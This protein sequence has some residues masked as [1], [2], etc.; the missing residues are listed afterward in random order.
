M[1]KQFFFLL[2]TISLSATANNKK[3]RQDIESIKSMCGCM[4]ISFEFAETIS[5]NKDYKFFD[6]Y[7]S[8]GL[9]LAFV[10]EESTNKIVIQ[11]LL[12]AG[13]D[14]IIKHWR[15]DWIYENTEFFNYD[16]D[17]TWKKEI[18]SKKEVKGQW[19][20]K[21]YQVDDSPRYQGSGSWVHVDGKH[22][23]ES[24][25]DAPLPR[26][27]YSKRSDYNVMQRKNRH[28]IT[29]YGWVHEQDNI[30]ILRN[31]D[32]KIIAEEKGWNKYVKTEDSK[33]Q[34]AKDWWVKNENYWREVRNAWNDFYNSKETISFHK[35]VDKK[36]MFSGFFELG[37]KAEE[38]PDTTTPNLSLEIKDI[39][40]KY[41]KK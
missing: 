25:T 22:Y 6:N 5:P 38:T 24:I 37:E 12:I 10:V 11:H 16:K 36:P 19:T 31:N 32:E 18:V 30:K 1:V 7:I 3:K 20:Q 35:S 33:C 41:S 8:G 27:E 34:A 23:W 14:M 2:L 21:V 17:L 4:D 26:R 28:E 15:Q 29:D 39:I 13:Q 9:E 40:L